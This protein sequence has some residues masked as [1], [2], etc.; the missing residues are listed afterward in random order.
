MP[1]ELSAG[2]VIALGSGDTH[3]IQAITNV[4]VDNYGLYNIT[5]SDG[6]VVLI[7]SDTQITR[8]YPPE[9]I[10]ST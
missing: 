8:I 5:F 10:P 3:T 6:K 4:G 1:H 9:T 7:K 2:D